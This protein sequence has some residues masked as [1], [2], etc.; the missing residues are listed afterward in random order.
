M[1]RPDRDAAWG[2]VAVAA[3]STVNLV[4]G[5]I[6]RLISADT[7]AWLLAFAHVNFVLVALST[8]RLLL[9]SPGTAAE[10]RARIAMCV[11]L[12]AIMVAVSVIADCLFH[13]ILLWA[14]PAVSLGLS[15]KHGDFDK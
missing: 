3:I 14:V 11:H 7:E 9:S 4:P 13:V 15:Y 1:A 8:R 2:V 6:R 12:L 5:I 10:R